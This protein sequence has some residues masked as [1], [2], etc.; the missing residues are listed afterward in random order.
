MQEGEIFY[1]LKYI[2]NPSSLPVELLPKE[3]V[4]SFKDDK[5]CSDLKTPFG[6]SGISYILDPKKN[7]N[8]TY[9][10]FFS[11]YYFE[12]GIKDMQPGF[13]SM[14]I[15]GLKETGSQK[16]ILGYVCKE[17]EVRLADS[18]SVR[19]VWYTEEIGVN[20]PNLHTPFYDINGVLMDFFYI[21]GEADIAFTADAVYAREI[22]DKNFERRNNYR[23]MSS[24]YLDS[25]IVKMISY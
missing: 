9:V 1:S 19:S 3:L 24:G 15:V 23:K 18:D 17:V 12:G 22:P 21:I 11:K 8:D 7:I 2:K 6:N 25:L 10:N 20:K 5:I 4:I 13:S 16:D 14:K